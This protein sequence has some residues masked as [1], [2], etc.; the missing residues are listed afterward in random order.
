[1]EEPCDHQTDADQNARDNAAQEQSGNG[2]LSADA[3]EDHL[4]GRRNDGADAAG[5]ADDAGGLALIVTG[6]FHN[7]QHH[8]ADCGGIS[9]CGAGHACEDH[10]CQNTHIAQTALE[11]AQHGVSEIDDT[12]GNT[13]AGHDLTCDHEE[14]D[15]QQGNAVSTVDKLL[16]QREDG[17]CGGAAHSLREHHEEAGADQ[18]ERN[19]NT[20]DNQAEQGD[21]KYS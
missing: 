7:R 1:M 15:G 11:A 3:V 10:G 21:Q 20:D 17:P 12:T 16:C 14:G 8:G 13:A 9:H 5:G 18:R 6:S 19:G 4:G 2:D